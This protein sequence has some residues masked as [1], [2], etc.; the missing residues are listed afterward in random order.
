MSTARNCFAGTR[1][2]DVLA[3]LFL[4]ETLP[5]LM[6]LLLLEEVSRP[7]IRELQEYRTSFVLGT[8]KWCSIN[9]NDV[10]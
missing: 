2:L 6:L 7:I 5:G 3:R 1:V 10:N 4:L 8:A 9:F